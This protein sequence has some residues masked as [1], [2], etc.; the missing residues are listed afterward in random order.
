VPILPLLPL[1]T[2]GIFARE[3]RFGTRQFRAFET[4]YG[5]RPPLR[6]QAP[7]GVSLGEAA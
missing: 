6:Q 4:A 3:L 1:V 5:W 2:L 7:L